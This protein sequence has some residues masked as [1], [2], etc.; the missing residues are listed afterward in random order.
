MCP[1]RLAALVNAL[2][3]AAEEDAEGEEE[4]GEGEE[5][6][7]APLGRPPAFLLA[8][9]AAA[10]ARPP[11]RTPG[12]D[13]AWIALCALSAAGFLALVAAVKR[14]VG[15]GK[16][17]AATSSPSLLEPLAPGEVS[18]ANPAFFLE[19]AGEGKV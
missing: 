19:A 8:S 2:V 16:G 7:R 15:G 13:W 9:A 18:G 12:V 6:T 5:G 17:K 1:H 3:A 11:S 14:V 10:P 4:E